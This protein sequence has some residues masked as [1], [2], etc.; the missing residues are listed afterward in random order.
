MGRVVPALRDTQGFSVG[1]AESRLYVVW[2]QAD[3]GP[4]PGPV[5]STIQFRGNR[6]IYLL[7]VD[8]TMYATLEKRRDSRSR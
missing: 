8:L 4:D 3:S 7:A 2:N 6:L 1:F 5:E